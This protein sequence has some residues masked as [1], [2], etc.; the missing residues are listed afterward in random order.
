MKTD[1]IEKI[2]FFILDDIKQI[3]SLKALN[4]RELYVILL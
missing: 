2:V 1:L 4:K 3:Q